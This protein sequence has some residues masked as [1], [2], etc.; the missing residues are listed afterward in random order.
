MSSNQ[1]IVVL[2]PPPVHAPRG[3]VASGLLAAWLFSGFA[4]GRRRE[5]DLLQLACEVEGEQPG[6]A[7]EL[8]GIA[9][10]EAAAEKGARA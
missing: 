10:H 4:R 7:R 1:R 6:L 9:M 3:A 5:R 2:I 8:R